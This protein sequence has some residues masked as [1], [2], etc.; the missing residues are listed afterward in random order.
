MPTRE[1]HLGCAVR[2]PVAPSRIAAPRSAA[3]E[4]PPAAEPPGTG[5][6]Y[7]R[8]TP[9]GAPGPRRAPG[10]RPC[11][12]DPTQPPPALSLPTYVLARSWAPLLPSGTGELEASSGDLHR[13]PRPRA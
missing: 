12:A 3:H 8:P 5:V 13:G 7:R 4:L 11:S 1:T 9:R 2:A 6:R 10:L